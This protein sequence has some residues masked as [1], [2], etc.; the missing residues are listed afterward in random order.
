MSLRTR[1]LAGLLGVSAVLLVVLS[2]ASVLVLRGHLRTRLEGQVQAATVTAARRVVEDDPL[3]QALT[4]STYAVAAYD[5]ANGTAHLVS[6]DADNAAVVPGLAEAL[7]RN[8]LL[9][10][11]ARGDTFDLDP[12]GENEMIAAAALS[13]SG[14]RLMVV[15]VPL[16]AVDDPVRHLLVSELTT[17]G[18]LILLLAAGGRLL[19]AGG[20]APLGKM[21]RTAHLVAEGGDLSARM[22]EGPSEV[23]R[24]GAAINLMLDRIADAFRDRQASEDRVRRFA[25]DASHELRTPL[26]TISGYAELYRAGAIPSEDLPKIMGRI[27][28]EANRMGRLVGEM[29]ELARLDRGTALALAETDLAELAREV[30]ADSAALDPAY[31]V[32]V[33]APSSLVA[34]VD[35]ARIRQVLVNLLGNVRAHTPE[36]TK[37]TVRILRAPGAVT[38]QVSDTGPGMSPEQ[39]ERAFD[40]F[41]RGEDHLSGGAGLGLS[42]VKAIVEAHGGRCRIISSPGGGTAVHI[43]LPAVQKATGG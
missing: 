15:A 23:G 7:G 27:E 22:P 3:A 16:D 8:R 40:R 37:A 42:I 10:Y 13:R 24:L 4:G 12:G 30:A 5:M 25:T 9:A 28:A 39:A 17:G 33:D 14:L 38:I 43:G 34:V 1:L 20:L 41:Q 36:E 2:L 6:G 29:L 18:V 31:P 26:S 21:A 32:T 19:I 35:E 11:A